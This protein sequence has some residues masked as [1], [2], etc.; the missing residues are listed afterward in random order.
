MAVVRWSLLGVAVV[1]G[2]HANLAVL[3][4]EKKAPGLQVDSAKSPG[5]WQSPPGICGAR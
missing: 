2:G 4:A 3:P 5:L 1:V